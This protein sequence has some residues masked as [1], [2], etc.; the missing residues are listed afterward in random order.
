M[1]HQL[2][3]IYFR[4]LKLGSTSSELLPYV[5][6]GLS[7]FSHLINIDFQADLITV[8]R[9]F[10]KQPSTAASLAVQASTAAFRTMKSQG[11][12][13]S[14]SLSLTSER[15]PANQRVVVWLFDLPCDQA[16]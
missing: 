13:Q 4:V 11:T 12:Y 6:E 16:M 2:F 7:K 3:T 15:S 10:C 5:L 9:D 8:L 1:L 14:L